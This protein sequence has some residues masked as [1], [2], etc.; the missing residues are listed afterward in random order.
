MII[1]SKYKC[2]PNISNTGSSLSANAFGLKFKGPMEVGKIDNRELIGVSFLVDTLLFCFFSSK[3]FSLLLCELS[4]FF[5]GF[6]YDE[7]Y[8]GIVIWVYRSEWWKN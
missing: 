6:L 2:I 8:F 3:I 1:S 4:N 7:K 5:S